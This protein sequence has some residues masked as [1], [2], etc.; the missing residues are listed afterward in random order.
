LLRGGSGG[1]TR[2]DTIDVEIMVVRTQHLPASE[3]IQLAGNRRRLL[4][5]GRVGL[6]ANTLQLASGPTVLGC[7]FPS[8]L[9]N[10]TEC[11][12]QELC[13]RLPAQHVEVDGGDRAEDRR[14]YVDTLDLP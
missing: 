13:G 10:G 14:H 7:G 8:Y 2:W 5:V 9:L 4:A 3:R 6:G 1:L 12:A 11:S